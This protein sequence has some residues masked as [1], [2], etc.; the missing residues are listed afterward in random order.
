MVSMAQNKVWNLVELPINF[1]TIGCKWVYKT[2]K[3]SLGI[4]KRYKARLIVK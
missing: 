3:N 1:K 2:K 4:I